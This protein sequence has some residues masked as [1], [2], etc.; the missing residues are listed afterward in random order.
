MYTVEDIKKAQQELQ[1]KGVKYC[2]GAYVDI[3]GVP[4]AKVVPLAHL[5][6]MA[7]G[8]QDNGNLPCR[9]HDFINY[10]CRKNG[11]SAALI[12]V[13]VL[14]FSKTMTLGTRA[15]GNTESSGSGPYG[16]SRWTYPSQIDVI[17]NGGGQ[18]FPVLR[19]TRA[20]D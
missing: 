17:I 9:Y 1:Q 12:E 4:K 11:L 16:F 18:K 20:S 6:H 10:G 5:E 15:F 13:E 2:V 8:G 19:W 7:H 14:G 3:H